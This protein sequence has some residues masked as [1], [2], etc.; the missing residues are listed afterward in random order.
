M[1]VLTTLLYRADELLT[2]D[3]ILAG[4]Y[5]LVDA[6]WLASA[7]FCVCV[8]VGVAVLVFVAEKAKSE[9]HLLVDKGALAV[10]AI[11][12]VTDPLYSGRHRTLLLRR[13]TVC[14]LAPACK[15]LFALCDLTIYPADQLLQCRNPTYHLRQ[16]RRDLQGELGHHSNEL[17]LAS[18]SPSWKVNR[19]LCRPRQQKAAYRSKWKICR[20]ASPSLPLRWPVL[21]V[22]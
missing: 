15:R 16:L 6:V 19:T 12:G 22:Y 5:E 3:S 1:E 21:W 18:V 4:C 10:Q 2:T 13:C 11:R 9:L 17:V 20:N 8:C 7:R 14:C